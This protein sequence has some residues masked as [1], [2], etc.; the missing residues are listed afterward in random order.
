MVRIPAKIEYE[1]VFQFWYC[2][3]CVNNRRG[4]RQKTLFYYFFIWLFFCIYDSIAG[5]WLD[6]KYASD[7]KITIKVGCRQGVS[8]CNL[9][10]QADA[11]GSTLGSIEL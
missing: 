4:E 9:L 11:Q 8:A 1:F 6:S 7:C 5:V 2:E 10:S 3:L